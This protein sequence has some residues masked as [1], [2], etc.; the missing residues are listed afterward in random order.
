M[1]EKCEEIEN[2]IIIQ[3]LSKH[4]VCVAVVNLASHRS[5]TIVYGPICAEADW[6][7]IRLP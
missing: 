6:H 7:S 4:K 1:Q 5:H 3:G 2:D